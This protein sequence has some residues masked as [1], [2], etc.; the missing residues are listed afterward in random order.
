[1]AT[2]KKTV[3]WPLALRLRVAFGGER[4]APESKDHV[5]Y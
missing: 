4:P 5:T 1:M 3:E 2:K